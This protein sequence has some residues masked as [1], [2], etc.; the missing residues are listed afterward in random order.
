MSQPPP[1]RRHAAVAAAVALVAAAVALVAALCVVAGGP[2]RS[3]AA[4]MTDPD[5]DVLAFGDAPFHGSTPDEADPVGMARTVDGEGY[6]QVGGDGGV[7]SFGSAAFSGSAG[8]IELAAPIVGMAAD[9]DGTGYWLVA[10]DGGVF[11]FDAGFFGSAGGV[12][13]EAPIVGMA[14]AADGAGYWLVAADGGVFSFGSAAFSGSAGGVDLAEAVVGMA[15]DPDGT[16]Y[17]LVASDGGVFS[18]DAEFFGSTGGVALA[19]RMTGMA[20]APDVAGYW[21]VGADGGV[22][23]FGD[24]EFHGGAAGIDLGDKATLGLAVRPGGDGYWLALGAPPRTLPGGGRSL[25][26][27]HRVVA[28]YGSPVSSALGTLGTGTLAQAA[29]RLQGQADAYRGAGR[30]VLPAFELIASL[31]TSSPGADG[32]YSSPLDAATIQ[33]HLDAVRRIGGLLILDL[34][35]GQADF[36]REARRYEA[37]LSQPDVGLA[38]DPE[39]HMPPGVT[40]GGGRIGSV[41]ASEVNEVSAYLERVVARHDLPEKLLVVH[42]FTQAMVQDRPS[43]VDRDGVAV[44]FHADGFGSAGAKRSKYA[45]LHGTDPFSSGFKLFYDADVGLMSPAEVLAMDPPPD[46]VSYQ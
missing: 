14:A 27:E 18:Y 13:L 2:E 20:S 32:D 44:T 5:E 21:L 26:P 3:A 24:A 28:Y 1:A 6:W 15:A 36:L 29:E 17:W 35:T 23:T 42:Q 37:F 39:W 7:F 8:G 30:P 43:V 25:F 19:A 40:P 38:L 33:R 45:A 12:A 31:A 34:Q 10:S 46:L 11:T 16:G 22:F 41:E 9:P 4:D